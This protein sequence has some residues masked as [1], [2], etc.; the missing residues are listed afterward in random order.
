MLRVLHW[1]LAGGLFGEGGHCSMSMRSLLASVGVACV[2]FSASAELEITE[3]CARCQS[4]VPAQKDLGW[5]ELHNNGT[6]AVNLA[7]YKL[8]RTNRGKA[9]APAN[10]SALCDRTVEPGAYTVVYTSEMFANGAA[11]TTVASY[12]YGNYGEIM[13]LPQKVNQ[14]KYP[15]V[16]LYKVAD[17]TL[18]QTVVV[19]VDLADNKSYTTQNGTRQILATPTPGAANNTTDAVAYGPNI[20][21]LYGVKKALDPWQPF[22]RA[23][24]GEDYSV[25]FPVN[26]IDLS[27]SP[28][29]AIQSVTLLYRVDTGTTIIAADE[30]P[31]SKTTSADKLLGDVYTATIPASAITTPGARVLFAAKITDGANRTFRSPSFKNPDD[32]YEWYG[33]IVE[34]TA[35][36]LSSTLQ[37][38][39]L[40]VDANSKAQMDT[41]ADKQDLTVV[42][43]NARCGIY[44]SS[45]GFYYDNVRID[46]RGNTSAGFAKKSHGLR[47]NKSQPLTCTDPVTG[48]KVT[49][50]RKSSF[51]SEYAD[52]SFLRQH[53]AFKLFNDYGS[54]APF[55][56]PVR[57]NLNGEFYQLAFHSERFTDEL[58]ED[59][60]GYDPLGYSYKNVGNFNDTTTNAGSIEKKTPDDDN[61][62][63]LAQLTTFIGKIAAAAQIGVDTDFAASP[64]Y[65]AA[66]TKV[67]VENFDLPAWINY[68][69]LARITH[70]N[71]DVW[72]NL[73]A[74]YDINGLGTW[75]PLAY[76]M[77]LSFG[78]Y[79]NDVS[80]MSGITADDDAFKSHPFYGGYH[81]RV[82]ALKT[83][84]SRCCRAVEA[85]WQSAKFRRL[86]LRRLRT[87]MDE[88]LK[89]PGTAK[90]ATPFWQ[91]ASSITN[92]IVADAA[93][94]RAKTPI[95][96][97]CNKIWNWG[98]SAYGM[99]VADGM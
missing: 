57:L 79:Y 95:G 47:F 3:I 96:S 60:Y 2:A 93:L 64:T 29:D 77:N 31:M 89:E 73:S 43:Y 59:C 66:L 58:I 41:D 24:V 74:Y 7:N 67:V 84:K 12:T 21:S 27:T 97:S 53:L 26:P 4:K 86:Y 82:E 1:P 87:L 34:P 70:E 71:D 16:Q 76:D 91:Y 51:T 63:D 98:N 19:P 38:L 23:K 33:T 5:V 68:L 22:P 14:K 40:F 62:K 69:A 9:P 46:L 32:G 10:I 25:S 42:P 13:V 90:E 48:T 61:E 52:P 36:Q 28:D 44:D 6:E 35:N 75:K 8:L 45:K 50:I 94:D 88:I 20:S 55:H 30:V 11:G 92:A 15:M 17:D 65:S 37:T 72:A 83:D 99:T 49:E 81:V 56:Y 78:Q 18:L 80:G 85:V 39:H 54:S